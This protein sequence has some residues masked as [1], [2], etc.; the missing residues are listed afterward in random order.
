[1]NTRIVVITGGAQGIGKAMAYRFLMD[2]YAVVIADADE[3]AGRETAADYAALGVIRF[4]SANVASE[5]D[6]MRL[7][8]DT[9]AAFGAGVHVLINNAAIACNRP[10]A[11]LSLADWDRVLGVN[12]TGPFLCAKHFAPSLRC[13]HGVIINIAST[14]ALMS[15]PNTEAYSA[16]KGGLV[17]LT[18]ALAASLAPDIRV[19]CISPG[20]IETGA[21]QKSSVRSHPVHSPADQTQHWAGRVGDPDD[22]AHFAAFLAS[23]KSGFV[24]GANMVVD[25]GM[26]HKMIYA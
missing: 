10:M 2:G 15:E 25:G 11:N 13:T 9:V 5:P 12:L 23:D 7:V 21:W 26:T 24:S 8:A 19:N 20:W 3:E 4:I 1:M 16:A 6:V 18:H 17:A 14:R 22:I